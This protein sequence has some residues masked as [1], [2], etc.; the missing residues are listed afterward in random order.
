MKQHMARIVALIVICT[1]VVMAVLVLRKDLCE[2]RIRTGDTEV[3]V[4]TACES[5]K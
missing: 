3:A 4:F 2:V 5:V 1:A